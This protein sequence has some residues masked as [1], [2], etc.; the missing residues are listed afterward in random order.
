MVLLA[1]GT[2]G[3]CLETCLGEIFLLV[4][5]VEEGV[6]NEGLEVSVL[7]EDLGEGKEDSG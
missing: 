2:A 1:E 6:L 4:P 7:G 3:P 5:C